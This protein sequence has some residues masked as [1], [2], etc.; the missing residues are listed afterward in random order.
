MWVHIF[1][2]ISLINISVFL[3][4]LGGFYLQYSLKVGDL[5]S[6]EGFFFNRIVLPVLFLLW[7][8]MFAPSMVM[9]K[10]SGY[11]SIGCHLL[12]LRVCKTTV[13]A[14]PSFRV[15]IEKLYVILKDLNS[16]DIWLFSLTAF[17]ILTLLCMFSVLTIMWLR[18]FLFW[19]TY[20]MFF[21]LLV[22][23]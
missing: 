16:Y 21:K 4:I 3:T 17:N 5:I 20:L 1:N 2:S 8:I 18:D 19:S 6:P 13:L 10:C 9:E 11:R 23:L 12:S 14:L 15:L 7:C 22:P